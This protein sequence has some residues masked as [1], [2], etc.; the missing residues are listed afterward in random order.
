MLQD[1]QSQQLK[2]VEQHTPADRTRVD[3]PADVARKYDGAAG[4]HVSRPRR[5]RHGPIGEAGRQLLRVR[6]RHL[7][8]AD[9]DP[10]RPQHL[11]RQRHPDRAHR[12]PRRR[13][14]PGGRE[15]QRARRLR[16]PEDRRLLRQLH[17]HRGHRRGRPKPL[18]PALDSIAAIRDRKDLARVLGS[19]LRADVDVFNATNFYTENLFGLWV[20]QDLDDPTHYSPFLLQGGLGMPDRSYYVDSSAA[21]AT[22]RAKYQEHIA[23]M[24]RLANIRRRRRQ[25][26]GDRPARDPHRR[27]ARE[28]ARSR[29]TS[30][31][32]TTT[33][34]G[35]ISAPRHRASTGRRTSPPP[36]SPSRR[37]SSSGSPAPSPAS[38]PSWRASRSTPGRTT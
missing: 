9:R 36:G 25:G 11:R 21:M 13:P 31:R 10:G 32:A 5:R 14:D 34:R 6:Q 16:P 12:P 15:G 28:P 30:P 24:L 27:G 17:G 7:A 29:A 8:Q 3:G 38:P 20:A 1:A 37:R 23:A 19:T 35:P 18:Q 26:R 2:T 33:G 4:P 22:I